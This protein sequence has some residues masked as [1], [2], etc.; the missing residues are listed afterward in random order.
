MHIKDEDIENWFTYHPPVGHDVSDYLEIR[1]AGRRFA[2]TILARTPVGADQSAA[3]RKV[4]E[5]VMTA[6]AAIACRR[7]D[8]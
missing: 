7:R 4:R 6:N 5:A 1:E 2:E 8:G 3:I